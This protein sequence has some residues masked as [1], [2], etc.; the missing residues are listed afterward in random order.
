MNSSTP[1]IDRTGSKESPESANHDM[2]QLQSKPPTSHSPKRDFRFW[3]IFASICVSLFLSALEFVRTVLRSENPS[4]SLYLR[5]Q[6][7]VS[8]ALPTIVH[9]LHGDDFVWVASAYALA[10]TALLPMTG[11]VAEVRVPQ[12]SPSHTRLITHKR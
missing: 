12:N 1:Q 7:S 3:L 2:A 8:T 10:S 11:G 6:T 5:L 9:D 4:L